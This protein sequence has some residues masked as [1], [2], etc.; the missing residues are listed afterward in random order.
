MSWP[1]GSLPP[2]RC[3]SRPIA[4]AVDERALYEMNPVEA[5]SNV[6]S[7]KVRMKLW[8]AEDDMHRLETPSISTKGWG[9]LR[10]P[11]AE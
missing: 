4:S 1:S 5:T 11:G 3:P 8:Y 10:I 6:E 9:C 2:T 7:T